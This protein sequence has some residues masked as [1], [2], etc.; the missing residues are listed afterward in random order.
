[1]SPEG[2]YLFGARSRWLV[3]SPAAVAQAIG[4]RLRLLLKEWFLDER[5]GLD[6][7]QILG[8]GTQTTRDREVQTRI[9]GTTGA[10]R[11]TAYASTIDDRDFRV[12]A[13]VDTIYGTINID[14]VF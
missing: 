2:D 9:L 14:E 5:V 13:T 3:D 4:T 8:T 12:Q 7:S 11:I 10:L 6:P 1:M